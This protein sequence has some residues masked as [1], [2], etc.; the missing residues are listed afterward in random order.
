MKAIILKNTGGVENLTLAEIEEPK[1]AANEVLVEVK[2]LG[3]NPVDF[4]VRQNEDVLNAI[5]GDQR[6][7]ILGWDIAGDIVAKGDAVT[8]FEIGDRVFG[9]INFVGAGNAY[10]ELV[11]APAD[12]L[13]KIPEQTSYAEAA[14]S[15]LAA[16]TALQVL[17]NKVKENDRVL[18]QGGSGGVGHF[19]IQIAKSLG[20]HVITT[21]SMKNKELVT[22]NL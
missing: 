22:D 12:H 19:A 13:A 14:A 10:A 6:P 5:Y 21:T 1:I 18:I 9:M 8:K 20:A 15:T 11:A 2:A 4:K 7:A 3:V 17:Q 16:L